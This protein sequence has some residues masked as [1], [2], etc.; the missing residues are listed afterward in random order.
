VTLLENGRRA[1]L[2]D[3]LTAARQAKAG[4]VLVV[5]LAGHGVN[6]GEGFYYLTAD[7][8]TADLDD[9]TV[10]ATTAL[11]NTELVDA[12]NAIPALKQVLILDT[13]ASGKFL[14]ALTGRRSAPSNQV[15]ALDRLK[16]RTGMFVLAGC[17]SDSVSYEATKYGQGLLTY[18]LLLGMKGGRLRESEFVDVA[19]LFGFAADKVPEL[20]RDI[21]GVQQPI[22]ACPGGCAFDIGQLTEADRTEVPLQTPRPLFSQPSLVDTDEGVDALDLV[23]R[24]TALLRDETASPRT[25]TLVFVDAPRFPGAFQIAGTY[26]TKNGTTSARFRLRRGKEAV[27]DWITVEGAADALPRQIVDEARKRL[28]ADAR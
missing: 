17:A 3:A 9:P 12:I 23:P 15:R 26:A 25:A 10:R 18:S 27:T 24:I 16:D 7:A 4:D 8:A 20:A 28:P 11:S 22:L 5:Y 1:A 2:V 19:L 21:G 14:E 13:C 6:R